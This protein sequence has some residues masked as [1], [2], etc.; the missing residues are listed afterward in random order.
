MLE[1]HPNS[2]MLLKGLRPEH[3]ND[4]ARKRLEEKLRTKLPEKKYQ[5]Y[6]LQEEKFTH[7]DIQL[8]ESPSKKRKAVD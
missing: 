2:L 5:K 4:G 3:L 6:S 7:W 8:E 1:S